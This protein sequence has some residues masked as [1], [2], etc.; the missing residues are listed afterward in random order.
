MAGLTYL[1]DTNILSEPLV[2][3]PNAAVLEGFCQHSRALALCA[4]TWQE[5][6]YGMFRLAPGRRRDQIEDYLFRRIRPSL[7][8]LSFDERAAHWQAAERARLSKAGKTP[9]YPDS[10]IAAIAAVNDCILVTRNVNDFRD[11]DGLRIDNWFENG[12]DIGA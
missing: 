9:A 1:L 8:I 11:F 6:L 10:E 2:R 7:P 4:I 3:H 12:T 5:M